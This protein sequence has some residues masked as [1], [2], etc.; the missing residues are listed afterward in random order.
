MMQIFE[1][2]VAESQPAVTFTGYLHTGSEEIEKDRRFP[3]MIVCGGGAYLGISDR[4]KEPVALYYLHQGF[5][6][7]VLTYQTEATGDPQY[8]QPLFDLAKLMKQI[9]EHSQEWLIDP[10][11]IAIVGF[12]A[13]A[14]LCAQLATHWHEA[15]LGEA[16]AVAD[17][18]L[19][20]PAAVILAYPL[21]D[22]L[23]QEKYANDDPTIDLSMGYVTTTKRAFMKHANEVFLGQDYTE[24]RMKEASPYYHVSQQTPPTFIWTTGADNLVYPQQSLTYANRLLAAGVPVELHLFE[25][26]QHGLSLGTYQSSGDETLMNQDVAVWTELALRF[27][28]RRFGVF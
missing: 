13:G 4:E 3:A 9:R 11:K 23:Q 15:W 10:E 26:G 25:E 19:L 1:E 22:F 28:H 27:L 12:S 7:F 18:Q 16:V 24:E 5:Q 20:R 8:P 14:N 21:L 6:V 17:N 2:R